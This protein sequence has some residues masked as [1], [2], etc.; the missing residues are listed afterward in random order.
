MIVALLAAA[1]VGP[2]VWSWIAYSR[3]Q[4]EIGVE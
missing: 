2:W 3:W 1:M 4:K